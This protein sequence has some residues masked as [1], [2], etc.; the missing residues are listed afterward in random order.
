MLFESVYVLMHV[1]VYVCVCVC[2]CVC[3]MH[4][5]VYSYTL[6][7]C[8]SSGPYSSTLHTVHRAAV[9]DRA[10]AILSRMWQVLETSPRTMTHN[11]CNPRNI[12]LRRPPGTK[13]TTEEPM[14]VPTIHSTPLSPNPSTTV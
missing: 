1:L 6:Q 2:V 12:C 9:I 8:V 7:H 10:I 11:D 13:T 14:R 5:L 4:V 3:V